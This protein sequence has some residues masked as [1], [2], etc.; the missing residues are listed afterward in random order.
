D[1]HFPARSRHVPDVGLPGGAAR[2]IFSISLLVGHLHVLTHQFLIR[3]R[4]ALEGDVHAAGLHEPVPARGS[5]PAEQLDRPAASRVREPT[6]PPGALTPELFD[7]FGS[8]FE[9]IH[10]ATNALL[11]LSPRASS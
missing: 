1:P 7:L 2:L 4:Q 10:K 8:E 5:Q 11:E 3:A 9:G 6:G